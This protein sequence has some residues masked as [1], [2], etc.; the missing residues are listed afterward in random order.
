MGQLT[1]PSSEHLPAP[2]RQMG[3]PTGDSPAQPILRPRGK[4]TLHQEDNEKYI[5]TDN[6][7]HYFQNKK[8][9]NERFLNSWEV[10]MKHTYSDREG[11]VPFTQE[12][13]ENTST[14]TTT[15][16]IFRTKNKQRTLP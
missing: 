2:L 15:T 8:I 11:K 1:L 10:T 6:N 3:K 12:D 16:T 14:Q 9:N 7:Y 13:N 5:D 4:G